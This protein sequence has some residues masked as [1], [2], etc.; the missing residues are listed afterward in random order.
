MYA[1][2]QAGLS[3]AQ[4]AQEFGITRQSVYGMFSARGYELRAKPP[5]G[6]SVTYDGRSYTVGNNGYYRCTTGDRHLLHRRMWEDARGPIPEDW[7]IHHLDEDKLHNSLDNF[8]CLPKSEHTRLYSP[9]CNQFSHK[10]AHR[11]AA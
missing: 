1:R 8:E 10:C 3:L 6:P 2:Y 9:N 5:M 4:V 7:D 11:E